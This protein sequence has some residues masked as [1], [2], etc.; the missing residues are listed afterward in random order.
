MSLA[1]GILEQFD[2]P[3][4]WGA[5]DRVLAAAKAAGIAA[6]LQSRNLSML[7]EVQKRGGRFLML[8]S[9][10]ATLLDGYKRALAELKGSKTV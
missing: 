3:V 9:D 6:G 8:G 5:V 2:S 1:L 10:V 4:F 7:A